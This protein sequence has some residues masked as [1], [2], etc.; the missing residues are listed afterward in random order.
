MM[1]KCHLLRCG[2]FN[3]ASLP[4]SSSIGSIEAAMLFPGGTQLTGE[5][6]LLR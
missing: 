1:L 3:M 2:A 6:D 4:P 5:L